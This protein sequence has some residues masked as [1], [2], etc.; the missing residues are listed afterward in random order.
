M[1]MNEIK[2]NYLYEK[3][4]KKYIFCYL[5]FILLMYLTVFLIIYVYNMIN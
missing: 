1:I 5:L 2:T 4:S 3:N